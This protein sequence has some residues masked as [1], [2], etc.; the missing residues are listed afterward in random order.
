MSTAHRDIKPHNLLIKNGVI[1]VADWGTGKLKQV[2]FINSLND[3]YIG[4][5]A[6][7]FFFK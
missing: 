4:S 3:D 2:K 1:K 6:Y 7:I 5:P